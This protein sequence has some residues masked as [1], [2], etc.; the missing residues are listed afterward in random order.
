MIYIYGDGKEL[1]IIYN[2]ETLTEADKQNV[3]IIKE[4]PPKET[5]A[6][7]EAILI[8]EGNTLRWEYQEILV[9]EDEELEEELEK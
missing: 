1:S 2:G 7:Y 9:I 3:F 8:K 6:G 4:L 5:P